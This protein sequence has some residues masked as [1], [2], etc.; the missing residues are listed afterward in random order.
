M[1]TQTYRSELN[2]KTVPDTQFK[3]KERTMALS[4]CRL[5]TAQHVKVCL[6]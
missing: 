5:L 3:I 4:S 6:Y 2:E 1:P